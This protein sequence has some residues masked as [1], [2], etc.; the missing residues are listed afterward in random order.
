MLIIKLLLR[1]YLYFISIFFVGRTCLFLLYFDRFSESNVNYYLSFLYGLRMDTITASVL[2]VM[3]ALVYT[4]TPKVF[5]KVS[6]LFLRAYFLIAV[7]MVLY[8]ENATFPF[9][10]QYDVRPNYLFVEYLEYP[11]E[12]VSMIVADYPVELV[13]TFAMMLGAGYLLMKKMKNMF[14]PVFE[15]KLSK[16]ALLLLPVLI[17]LFIGIRSSFGHRPANISDAM[18]SNNRVV[19][20]ITKNSIYS[21]GYAVYSNKAHGENAIK[22]YGKM[23]IGEALSRVENI[24]NIKSTVPEKPFYRTTKSH[25]KSD[26]PKN[27]VILIEESLG[28]Q[29]VNNETAPNMTRLKNEGIWFDNLFSNGTRSIR[30]IAGMTSGIFSVPGKGVLKRNKAQ[31]DFFTASSLLKPYGYRSLFFYGGESRF[32]NMKGWFSGNGFDE[33]VDQEKIENPSFVS[34]WGVSDE[35]LLDTANKRFSA[36]HGQGQ[37]FVSIIFSTSNHTPFDVPIEKIEPVS[38]VPEKS[39]KNAVKYADYTI[40]GF[41]EKAREE[42]YYSDTV[43]VIVADHNVRVYGDDLVPVNM[44]HI[45]GLILG[46]DISPVVISTL[47]T[48]PDLLATAFDLIGIDLYHPVMGK[49]VFDDSKQ[50]VSLMQFN[51][52]YALRVGDEVVVV[53]PGK[54]PLTFKYRDEHLQPAESNAELRKDTLAFIVVLNYLY[55][56][57]LYN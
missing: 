32:D 28:Y 3:P 52:F 29:F 35:D 2:L 44:F 19:N 12:V 9:F 57:R 42:P 55:D 34:T 41:I 7:S 33:I 13:V 27:L 53:R 50:E 30:G 49:S 22:K 51:D 16:R 18:Y 15:V 23:E 6:D 25:F 11:R 1:F 43:F 40:G 20:E 45:P 37:K 26:D 4:L 17:V 10:A 54:E 31:K 38:G 24:L 48:Q 46:G 8:V 5:S 56:K 36:L 21:I 39:V 14:L 47:S